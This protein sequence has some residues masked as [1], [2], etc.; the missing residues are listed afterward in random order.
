VPRWWACCG[1]T[2]DKNFHDGELG[3]K[4]SAEDNQAR[5]YARPVAVALILHRK[6]KSRRDDRRDSKRTLLWLL[7][8]LEV[9]HRAL[10]GFR[11]FPV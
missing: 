11:S 1:I 10:V 7:V 4:A 6:N 5:I 8:M 9:L 2:S 3:S